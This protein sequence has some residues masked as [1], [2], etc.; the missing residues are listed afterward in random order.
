MT[1]IDMS[2]ISPTVTRSISAALAE[3]GAQMLDAPVSGGDKGAR[4]L[5]VEPPCPLIP[6]PFPGGE[7]DIDLSGDLAQ[8][9]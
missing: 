8:L 4:A 7:V 9:E 2:T 5:L 6:V 1:V 3:A